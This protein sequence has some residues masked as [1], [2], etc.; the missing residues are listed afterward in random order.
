MVTY[1]MCR[2]IKEMGGTGYNLVSVSAAARYEGEVDKF[3]GDLSLVIWENKSP[4]S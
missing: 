1:C 4:G 3:D 2:G